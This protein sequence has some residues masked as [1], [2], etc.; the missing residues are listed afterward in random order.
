MSENL[1]KK[2]ILVKLFLFLHCLC[3]LILLHRSGYV[4]HTFL[5]HT[6]LAKRKNLINLVN[7]S[8]CLNVKFIQNF[9]KLH[10]KIVIAIL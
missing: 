6:E 7:F 3:F 9:Y 1:K 8:E 2:V 5:E 10:L 4:C